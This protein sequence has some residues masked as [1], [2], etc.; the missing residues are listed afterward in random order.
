MR[1]RALSGGDCTAILERRNF[2]RPALLAKVAWRAGV[3][4][5]A[6]LG[7]AISGAAGQ[8]RYEVF[9]EMQYLVAR[10]YVSR[11]FGPSARLSAPAARD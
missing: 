1:S 7:E 5:A 6:R 2:S 4:G 9:F 10:A 11:F 8:E 3:L